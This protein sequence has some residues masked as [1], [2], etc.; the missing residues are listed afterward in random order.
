MQSLIHFKNF[1]KMSEND[2]VLCLFDIEIFDKR[3]AQHLQN[4]TDKFDSRTTSNDP[5]MIGGPSA[6]S[7]PHRGI[8]MV[9]NY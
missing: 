3:D 9:I 8:V 6:S 5:E 7:S 2:D 4:R 1:S